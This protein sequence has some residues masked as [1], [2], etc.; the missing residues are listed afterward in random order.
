[1]STTAIPKLYLLPAG[2]CPRRP[3]SLFAM[4]ATR[5]LA[6]IAGH[7]DYY[8]FDTPPIMAADDVSNLAPH[9]DGLIM[10]IR[11]GS[12]SGRVAKTAL[13]LLRLRRINIIGLVLNAVPKGRGHYPY[14]ADKSYHPKATA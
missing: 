13:D 4:H 2:D 6:D 14:Y 11:S 12:T 8:V 7:Y 9:V 1:V 5:F 10:V 3:G